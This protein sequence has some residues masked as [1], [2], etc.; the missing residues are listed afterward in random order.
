[1]LQ[2][3]FSYVT[4]APGRLL[5]RAICLLVLFLVAHPSGAAAGW[6]VEVDGNSHPI[7][8]RGIEGV[9]YLKVSDIARAFGGRFEQDQRSGNFVYELEDRRVVLSA[10]EGLA[11]LDAEILT[12]SHPNRV[13][14]G[15]LW[16]VPA[17][18]QKAVVPMFKRPVERSG[19]RFLVGGP[20]PVDIKFR[21]SH[22]A[23][24]TRIVL[25]LSRAVRY[26]VDSGSGWVRLRTLDVPLRDV[27]LPEK[28]DGTEVKAVGFEPGPNGTGGA[29]NVP[30]AVKNGST[31]GSGVMVAV[32]E[33]SLSEQPPRFKAISSMS[34]ATANRPEPVRRERKMYMSG[35][36]G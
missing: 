24:G 15:E 11:S 20:A 6:S 33:A 21:T 12:F 28:V 25:E 30:T 31:G 23:A 9:E 35:L 19:T 4:H 10:T 1:M 2:S 18:V 32:G 13:L 8:S 26:E 5:A 27:R 3:P 14:D 36:L 29:A 7:A 22:D 16:V 34:A 17:F